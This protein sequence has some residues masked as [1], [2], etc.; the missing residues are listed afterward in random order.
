MNKDEYEI[1]LENK[2]AK[3]KIL[4]QKRKALKDATKSVIVGDRKKVKRKYICNY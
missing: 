2:R 3:A 4:R 1:F